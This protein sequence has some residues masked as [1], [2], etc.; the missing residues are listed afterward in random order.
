MALFKKL[1][2][3]FPDKEKIKTTCRNKQ[4]DS[5]KPFTNYCAILLSESFN[6]SGVDISS[7]KGN[8]CWS[9]SGKKHILLAHDFANSLAQSTLPGFGKKEKV[10]PATF[11]QDLKGR[12]GIVYFK[13][14]WQRGK[15]S[16]SARSGDHIDLW[17]ESE[18]TSSSMWTR[19][20]YEFFGA[21][22][23]LNK[24]KEVW[25]WEVK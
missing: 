22:S 17:N 16:F 23:D 4:K 19:S 11:Q 24:S 6:R 13:D 15:E 9:H 2:D 8:K 7:F 1:W 10:S 12:T 14:Y 3:N 20:I 18:I 5:N 21:V 25:F